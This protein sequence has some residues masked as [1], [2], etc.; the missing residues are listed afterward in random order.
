MTTYTPMG[1][2][3]YVSA[4]GE[5]ILAL[6]EEC[7]LSVPQLAERMGIPF[8][9]M[10]VI[11]YERGAITADVA[12]ALETVLAAPARFW[13]AREQDYRAFLAQEAKAREEAL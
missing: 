3:Y 10:A 2:P 11:V 13:L 4:P 6:L 12:A 5:T 7:G 1:R 9:R 8:S